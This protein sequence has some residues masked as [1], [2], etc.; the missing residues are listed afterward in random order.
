MTCVYLP[1]GIDGGELLKKVTEAG[2]TLA[3]GLHKEIK[4]KYFR[5]GHMG[6]SS[7]RSDHLLAVIEALESALQ[8]LGHK[9]EKGSAIA[10]FNSIIGYLNK[11]V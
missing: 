11:G 9:F 4:T 8:A 3:G 2:V 6:P 10:K 5:I 1:E 7:R